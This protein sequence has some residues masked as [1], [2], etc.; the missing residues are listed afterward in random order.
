LVRDLRTSIVSSFKSGHP[1]KSSTVTMEQLE[2]GM[3]VCN[4]GRC[5]SERGIRY[6]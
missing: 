5:I 6:V 1:G 2:V 4:S 3:I